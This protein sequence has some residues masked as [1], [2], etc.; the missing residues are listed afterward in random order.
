MKTIKIQIGEKTLYRKPPA[1]IYEQGIKVKNPDRYRP[2]KKYRSLWYLADSRDI[3]R[4]IWEIGQEYYKRMQDPG[5][6]GRHHIANPAHFTKLF[7]W[8]YLTGARQQEAFLEPRPTLEI[9]NKEGGTYIILQHVNQKHKQSNGARE[10]VTATI[11][12]LD[13]WEQ[14]MWNF[15]TDEGLS[16][17]AEEIF[18]YDLW[19]STNKANITGLV[20]HSFFTNLKDENGK[21]HKGEG[22]FPHMLRHTRAYNLLINHN[23]PKELVKLW[24]GWKLEDMLYYYAQIARIIQVEDQLEI[25]KDRRLLTDLRVEGFIN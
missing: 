20:K 13:I 6:R 3:C 9:V 19:K 7:Y 4:Q 25:L 21:V 14:K 5:K 8:L 11:P 17:N 23:I 1:Y 15:I 16:T 22:I 24:M 12:I 18:R 10:I 2:E